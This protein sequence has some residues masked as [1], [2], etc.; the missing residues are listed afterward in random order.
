MPK[1]NSNQGQMTI[2]L[3]RPDE[4]KEYLDQYIIGQDEAKKTLA[5]AVYNHYKRIIHNNNK[6]GDT[7]ITKSNCL[8]CGPT[9][10]GKTEIIRVIAKA[11]QV[12]VYQQDGTALTASGYVGADVE[13][14]LVGLLR[15]CDYDINRAQL[16]IVIIDEADKLSKKGAG[17]SITRDVS[18]E[19]V[20]QNLLR[21]IE[22]DL[23][24]VPPAGGRKH[25]EQSLIWLDTTNILFIAL[26]AFI[27]LEDIIKKRIGT[28]RIGF[29]V[30][31]E[32]N[33]DESSYLDYI[34]PQDLRDYGFIPEF[35]GRFPVITSVEKLSQEALVRILKEPKNSI[36]KQY[37]ELLLMDGVELNFDDDALVEMANIAYDYDTGARALRSVVEKVMKDV[38]YNAPKN[39]AENGIKKITI[40]KEMVNQIYSKYN[41]VLRKTA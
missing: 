28:H 1:N 26:G 5:V 38:M 6:L 34:T 2:N 39:A 14:C 19:C 31:K 11:L 24:G 35:I 29:N 16:G 30:V 10:S 23:V 33:I 20:Q 7:E 4:I 41:R 18:G 36:I 25:P 12:P 40:T 13:E 27:G 15:E 3:M 32:E 17:P 22:G 9:G 37:K 8:I 21:M